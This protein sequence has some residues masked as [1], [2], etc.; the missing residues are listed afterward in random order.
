MK[1]KKTILTGLLASTLIASM[2]MSAQAADILYP[3]APPAPA[4]VSQMDARWGGV[5]VGVNGGYTFGNSDHTNGIVGTSGLQTDGFL[6]G[7][8][9]GYNYQA[10][11]NWVYG[12]EGDFAFANA[13]DSTSSAAFCATTCST[14][15][16][17][18][19]TVRGR[20]GY[21]YGNVLPYVTGGLAIA[22]VDARNGAGSGDKTALGWTA[23]LGVEYL[24]AQ[25]VSLK[26]EYLYSKFD[27][28][29]GTGGST[30]ANFDDMHTT[31]V[32]LNIKF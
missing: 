11:N 10:N 21:A 19:G 12:L 16:N 29:I 1:M 25:N 5:Y 32:G 6:G 2:G 31:R 23:G 13:D 3:D 22:D 14:D 24:V 26:G 27:E 4:P 17:W 28:N 18:F 8:T 20:A 15:L 30:S 7:V 9:A